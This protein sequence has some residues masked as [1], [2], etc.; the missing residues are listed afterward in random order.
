MYFVNYCIIPLHCCAVV[1]YAILE[2]PWNVIEFS[3]QS[4][5]ISHLWHLLW[6]FTFVASP[7]GLW[8]LFLKNMLCYAVKKVVCEFTEQQHV[9]LLNR[10]HQVWSI[11]IDDE[12]IWWKVKSLFY[13]C[14]SDHLLN[15]LQTLT[16]TFGDDTIS[17]WSWTSFMFNPIISQEFAGSGITNV[18]ERLWNRKVCIN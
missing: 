3:F 10:R 8:L 7:L 17:Q 14:K 12:V 5:E 6:N 13:G 11:V 15:H 2:I 4:C 18:T 1:Y 9:C 16:Q